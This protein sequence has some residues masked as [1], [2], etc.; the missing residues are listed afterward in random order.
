MVTRD[1]L[2]IVGGDDFFSM[3]PDSRSW[4]M[5][6]AVAVVFLGIWG[7][8]LL[9]A[10]Q[11]RVRRFAVQALRFTLQTL[12]GL[13]ED[14]PSLVELQVLAAS[15]AATAPRGSPEPAS[16]S[17]DN[18]VPAAPMPP[19]PT[20]VASQCRVAR[21][22]RR[23]FAV[24]DVQTQTVTTYSAVRGVLHPRFDLIPFKAGI[25]VNGEEF[26]PHSTQDFSQ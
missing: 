15:H 26:M 7:K 24:R 25:W 13:I 12:L 20:Y 17:R 3:F 16:S 5:L 6:L 4:M 18:F 14:D 10:V 8:I 1:S 11:R 23:E 21:E 9:E 19:S 2:A 22:P